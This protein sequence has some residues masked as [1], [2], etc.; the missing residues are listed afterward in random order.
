M[1]ETDSKYKS[2]VKDLDF[3]TII[4]LL[5]V[6]RRKG[7]K[8]VF[9]FFI[10]GVLIAFLSKKEYKVVSSYI[11]QMSG[12]SQMSSLGSIAS[13]A[14]FNLGEGVNRSEI[15]PI[16]YPNVINSTPFKL[17]VLKAELKFNEL[18][19][20]VTYEEYYD[21]YYTPGIFWYLKKY[22]L[23]LPKIIISLFKSEEPKVSKSTNQNKLLSV[24][25]K[26]LGL[27]SKMQDQISVSYNSKEGFLE[28]T[29]VMPEAL[30][31][32]QLAKYVEG[33]L[34][35]KVIEFKIQNAR[36]QLSYT[37]KQYLEK[38]KEFEEKRELLTSF[39]DSN[40]NISRS[41]ALNRLKDLEAEYNLALSVY[42][43]LAKQLEQAKLRVKQDTP[44]FSTIQPVVVP[45]GESA[46]KK[47]LIIILFIF[48]GAFSY[49]IYVWG[50]A[51]LQIVRDNL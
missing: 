13:M 9:V 28:L 25:G 38:K 26:Q 51:Y 29:V 48:L 31:A 12:D 23:G 15:P 2:S 47:L 11:P 40:Q 6:N 33:L 39:K 34:Q 35:D 14:G 4:K 19:E 49:F 8:I 21:S 5:W 42:T 44:I 3:L 45:V 7:Y 18:S 16:L 10:I 41:T 43:E 30:A 17:D 36:E 24:T 27:F 37:K 50:R 46:P 22:T 32:A 1:K 20:T